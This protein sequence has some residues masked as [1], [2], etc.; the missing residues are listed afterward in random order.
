MN[1]LRTQSAEM[2]RR[3]LRGAGLAALVVCTLVGIG[4]AEA[5]TTSPLDELRPSAG[6]ETPTDFRTGASDP[7]PTEIVR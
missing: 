4:Q 3:S 5:Q 6:N 2:P 7:N 1:D